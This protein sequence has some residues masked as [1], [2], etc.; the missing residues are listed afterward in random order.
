MPTYTIEKYIHYYNNE[1][2]TLKL[3]GLTPTQYRNQSFN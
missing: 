1:R 3:K 2:I